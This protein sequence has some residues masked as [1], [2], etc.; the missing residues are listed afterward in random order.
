MRARHFFGSLRRA[1]ID[2][3]QKLKDFIVAY[4]QAK[5]ARKKTLDSEDVFGIL[6]QLGLWNEV[7]MIWEADFEEIDEETVD[8]VTADVPMAEANSQP[9]SRPGQALLQ[10]MQDLF[11]AKDLSAYQQTL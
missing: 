3:L 2:C 9:K 8:P 6:V 11:K 10:A 4:V 5:K 7:K 1:G